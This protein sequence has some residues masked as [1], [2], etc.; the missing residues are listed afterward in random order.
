MQDQYWRTKDESH[1]LRSAKLIPT[2]WPRRPQAVEN[3]GED[4]HLLEESTIHPTPPNLPTLASLWS[5]L[6]DWKAL[7]WPAFAAVSIATL[8][9]L[10][11]FKELGKRKALG[12]VNLS[13][14]TPTQSYVMAGLK[15]L[16]VFLFVVALF[17]FGGMFLHYKL[18]TLT[19]YYSRFLTWFRPDGRLALLP[20]P[21]AFILEGWIIY[22]THKLDQ[23][24]NVGVLG[25]SVNT[26]GAWPLSLIEG[27][28]KPGLWYQIF[29][30]SLIVLMTGI[31]LWII[32]TALS[33]H[34]YRA[35]FA[36]WLA[37]SLIYLMGQYAFVAGMSETQEGF[38]MVDSPDIKTLYEHYDFRAFL[39]DSDEKTF[40]LMIVTNPKHERD[41]R[42]DGRSQNE[43][44]S[45]VYL[46]RAQAKWMTVLGSVSL[47]QALTVGKDNQAWADDIGAPTQNSPASPVEKKAIEGVAG[48][49][50]I[51]RPQALS[52]SPTSRDSSVR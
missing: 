2:M 36:I 7:F 20:F 32:I 39:I 29:F 21:A 40:A 31:Y 1:Q 9:Y 33:R 42:R 4:S 44:R 3:V 6:Q 12:I 22:L 28:S 48:Q 27:F 25:L 41:F 43:H 16:E 23:R 30:S 52:D 49:T 47:Y 46:P 26:N 14:E 50:R 19:T 37:A 5:L 17:V 13:L 18:P 15:S 45:I 51:T 10:G 8:H 34:L 35:S 24:L 11:I 38:P